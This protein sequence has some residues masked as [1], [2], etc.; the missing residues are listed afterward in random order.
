MCSLHAKHILRTLASANLDIYLLMYEQ[1]TRITY[2]TINCQVLSMYAH[3]VY[4][5]V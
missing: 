1:Y 4:I 3:I 2:N 5:N